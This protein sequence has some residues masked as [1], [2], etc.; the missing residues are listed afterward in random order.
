MLRG[1]PASGKS[2]YTK[3]LVAKGGWTRVNKDELRVMLHGGK[4]SRKNE[5]EVI[6]CRNSVILMA[7]AAGKNIVV[8][9]TNFAPKH[10]AEL[11]TLCDIVSKY[12]PYEFEVLDFNTDVEECIRRDLHRGEKAVGEQVIRK[13]W[14]EYL[15]P[16]QE[17]Y[18]CGGPKAVI[19]DID[20][21][22]A[23]MAGRGPF[24]WGK[25]GTDSVDEDVAGLLDSFKRDNFKVLIFSGRDS[26]CQGETINWLKGNSIAYDELAMRPEGDTRK[27]VEVKREFYEAFKDTYDIRYVVDDRAQVCRMWYEMGLCLLKVGDPDLE[28]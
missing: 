9:D 27:D 10:E 7:M 3:D 17:P 2:T 22:L 8:D 15:A 13:M 14:R 1:L 16:R 28:F 19:F 18:I 23:H 20:G 5:E 25:V 21:T 11:G 12:G 6:Q 26:V 24:D 4:W